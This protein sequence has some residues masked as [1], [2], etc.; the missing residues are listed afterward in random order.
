MV[1]E[2]VIERMI[3]E[4]IKRGLMG[5]TESATDVLAGLIHHTYYLERV[6]MDKVWF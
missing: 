1:I 5:L 3:E 2:W 6:G 4:Q